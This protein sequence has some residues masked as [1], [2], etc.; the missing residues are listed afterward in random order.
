MLKKA[1]KWITN[2]IGFKI[3]ALVL[4]IIVWLVIINQEDPDKTVVFT[5]SVQLENADYLEDMGKTYEILGGTDTISF[6]VTG[7]RSV[8]EGMSASDFTA[9]A[10]FEE[11]NE[12]MTQ[13]PVRL[14]ARSNSSRLEIQNRSQYVRVNVEDVVS[15]ELDVVA[16][17]DGTPASG[18]SVE[19]MES[20]PASISITGP[21]SIVDQVAIAQATIDVTGQSDDFKNYADVVLL[22]A[23][24]E[25]VDTT[26]LTISDTRV[27][28]S[29]TML[30][31][32]TLALD[33][34]TNGQV[35]D[36]CELESVTGS[37][38]EIRVEGAPSVLANLTSLTITS[39]QLNLD[40]K[41]ES[42]DV[43][44][45]ITDYL[46]AGVTLASG[47]SSTLSVRVEISGEPSLQVQIPS[48][49][50]TIQNVPEGYQVTL[51][52]ETVTFTIRGSLDALEGLS[53]TDIRPVADASTVTEAT[54]QLPLTLNGEY[55]LDKDVYVDITVTVLETETE[56]ETE[57]GTE[58]ETESG[59]ASTE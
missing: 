31:E 46:P 19:S 34:R 1:A 29:V 20:D 17:S 40:H 23:E 30:E 36:G 26:R 43:E 38:S 4:A 52:S 55:S 6:T 54:T 51:D 24:G 44:L 15:K 25:A 18:C 11:I 5:V 59:E 32:K 22:N 57:T 35:P 45:D 3:L 2:N 56:A 49:Q 14:A 16:I 10:D 47:E 27:T 41:S 13:I 33:I 7:Q 8:V 12:D 53:T 21:E 42:Y 58:T 9:T 50:I 39:S 48:D 37:K 28:V